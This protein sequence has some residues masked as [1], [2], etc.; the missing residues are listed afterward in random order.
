MK[1]ILLYS[2]LL[3]TSSMA[4]AQS[5]TLAPVDPNNPDKGTVVFDN[6]TNLLKYWNGTVWIPITNTSGTGWAAAGTHIF[7]TNEGNVGVGVN[8]PKAPLNVGAGKTVLFGADTSGNGKKFIWYGTKGALRAGVIQ[9]SSNWNYANVGENSV[10]IGY[11]TLATGNSSIALGIGTESSNFGTVA[12]GALTQASGE[13]AVAM[14]SGANATGTYSVAM[15]LSPA[16][17]GHGSIAIGQYVSAT[18]DYSTAFGH[19]TKATGNYS[20]AAGY[21]C[22]TKGNYSTTF[23]RE[24]KIT[25]P[26]TTVVGQY[27]FDVL[28]D[29]LFIVGNGDASN[30]RRN[31]FTVMKNGNIGISN[32][33]PL[34]PLHIS[35]F[36]QLN[37]T[38]SRYFSNLTGTDIKG[39]ADGTYNAG[40]I[41]EQNIVTNNNFISSGSLTSSDA[42]IKNIIGLSDSKQDLQRLQ[43]IR[44]TDYLHKDTVQRGNKVFKKVIAQQVEEVYPE[45]VN[46][47]TSVIPDI[48]SLAQ[49]VA[50]DI[51]SKRLSITLARNYGLKTG[52][53]VKLIHP[54]E[55]DILAEIDAVEGN[56]FRVK[57]WHY[58]ADKIFVYGRQVNDFRVVDYEALS[59]LGISAIQELAKEVEALK[60]QNKDIKADLT[61]RLEAIESRL[62][63]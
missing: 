8:S 60:K 10:A 17:S 53:K 49:N 32:N 34:A 61:A 44:I 9:G 56:I 7:N 63:K 41:V 51:A 25:S 36:K 39:L 3:L 11:N 2:F 55:G 40:L 13:N 16:A 48:Y 31:A 30:N 45:A 58:S 47:I 22:E 1:T 33:N 46:K 14:G 50:Y 43:Q 21:S 54:T 35:G 38:N 15:G 12:M 27:N 42:R 18:G 26:N 59:M 23:G 24:N 57:D 20:L 37:Y 29:A 4:I 28:Q 6:N 62:V 52:D 19:S 5:V